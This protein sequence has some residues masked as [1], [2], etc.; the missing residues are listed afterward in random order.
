MA[1]DLCWM[2][3]EAGDVAGNGRGKRKGRCW[4]GGGAEQGGLEGTRCISQ[5][6]VAAAAHAAGAL[7]LEYRRG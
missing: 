3:R 6:L 7:T 5:V 2:I 1:M 4:R